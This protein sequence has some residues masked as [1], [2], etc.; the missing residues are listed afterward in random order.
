MCPSYST[1]SKL[2]ENGTEIIFVL[3]SVC[4]C[5][6]NGFLWDYTIKIKSYKKSNDRESEPNTGHTTVM[7]AICPELEQPVRA[8]LLPPFSPPSCRPYHVH[9]QT[10]E[11]TYI[12]ATFNLELLKLRCMDGDIMRLFNWN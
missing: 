10:K 7:T 2:Q 6:P 12:P 9:Y 4:F 1:S 3:L 5:S 8:Q 11:G